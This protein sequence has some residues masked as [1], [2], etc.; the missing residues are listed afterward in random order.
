MN[1]DLRR[2]HIIGL[3][4]GWS[5]ILLLGVAMPLKYWADMPMAVTVVG[6][7]HG[8]LFV[9]YL[10]SLAEVTIKRRWSI[11]KVLAGLLASVLPLGP[12][13]LDAKLV[14]QELERENRK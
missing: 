2:F 14:K 8:L 13:I 4:E 6:S 3:T 11:L 10:L 9:L 5:F 12:F 7:L 1:H